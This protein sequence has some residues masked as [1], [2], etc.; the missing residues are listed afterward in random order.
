MDDLAQAIR[1][2]PLES[3]VPIA[4]MLVIGLGMWAAGRRLARPT[5]AAAGLLTGALCG[6]LIADA[7]GIGV[8]GWAAALVAGLLL[9]CI[10][11]LAYRASVA[12]GL[13]VVLAFGAPLG[14][15]AIA[16]ADGVQQAILAS[17]ES[18]PP[19]VDSEPDA[20]DDWAGSLG[21]KA[22]AQSGLDEDITDE[23]LEQFDHAV[24]FATYLLEHGKRLW[25]QTP[26]ELRQRMIGAGVV[27]GII[28]FLVGTLAST[29][30]ASV[31]TSF[32]GAACWMSG[33]WLAALR[34]GVPETSPLVPKHAGA[35]LVLW[36]VISV[37]GLLIQWT[38]RPKLADK[39]A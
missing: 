5:F 7:L 25:A 14:I 9:A 29:V 28:G 13:A 23:L 17:P 11:T 31:V 2:L 12:A 4:L 24:T 16:D 10:A 18:D 22:A 32:G 8:P 30:S 15:W 6:W 26:P 38:I 19:P 37:I 34:L 36:V 3:W 35:W 20:L 33:A 1:D 39:P 21:P 27:A